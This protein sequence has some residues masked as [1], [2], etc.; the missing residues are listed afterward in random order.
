[1]HCLSNCEHKKNKSMKAPILPTTSPQPNKT[2]FENILEETANLIR[3]LYLFSPGIVF[4]LLYYF[5]I[6]K[7][8]MGQDMLMQAVE[9]SGPFIFTNLSVI[10]WMLLSWLS[11]RQISNLYI[12]MH[13]AATPWI[14]DH[15]PR[16]LGYNVAV[17]L[18]LAALYL[19]TIDYKWKTVW[20]FWALFIFHNAYYFLLERV[21][22]LKETKFI[23]LGVLIGI[24]YIGFLIFSFYGGSS[25]KVPFFEF[26]NYRQHVWI[27]M[28]LCITYFIL[29]IV[30][31]F[32]AVEKRKKG[33]GSPNDIR[34]KKVFQMSLFLS[35]VLYSVILFSPDFANRY[36]SLGCLLLA[37]GLWVAFVCKIKSFAVKYNFRFTMLIVLWAIIIGFLYDPY[38]VDLENTSAA[39][40]Y[41]EKRLGV[42]QYLDRWIQNPIRSKMLN[43]PDRTSYPVYMVI[44]DGGASKSGYWVASVLSKLEE[45]DDKDKFS[46]HLLSIAGAS[47]GSVGNLAFYSTLVNKP[48]AFGKLQK[49]ISKYPAAKFMETDFLTYPLARFLGPDLLRHLIPFKFMD[50]RAEALEAAMESSDYNSKIGEC[51]KGTLDTVFEYGGRLPIVFINTTN[52][53]SGSPGVISNIKINT[54]FTHRMDVLTE[55]DKI[56]DCGKHKNMQL[57]TAAVLGARFPYLSPAGEI[58]NKYFVDGGYYDNSGGGITSELLQRIE[59]RMNNPHDTVFYKLRDK[60]KFRVIYISNGVI[61]KEEPKTLHP[62]VNDLAAPLLTVLGTY[63]NQTDL[64]NIKLKDYINSKAFGL[65]PEPF[66]QVNLPKNPKDPKAIKIPYPMNWVISDYNIKRMNENLDKIESKDVLSRN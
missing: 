62:L 65:K 52:I 60:L 30:F 18:Q 49:G 9:Y 16:L 6:V 1:M 23:K 64:S 34:W 61:K 53:E 63:G 11:S 4:L 41:T 48:S 5:V 25:K 46:D 55:V 10:L 51:F 19:P 40:I 43:R 26:D 8:S 57:S 17:V 13:G 24:S 15:F 20:L 27:W 14:Y 7:L 3:A 66:Y 56:N 58:N 38:D 36:G 29:Q 31:V 22:R 45:S 47:G 28:V 21:F 50:D 59:M 39:N 37:M 35:F 42:D 2:V 44:S 33:K 32:L 12:K 54:A